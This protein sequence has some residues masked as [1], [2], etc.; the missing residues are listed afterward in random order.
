MISANLTTDL[1]KKLHDIYIHLGDHYQ[2]YNRI[3]ALNGLAGIALFQ[4]YYE[5]RYNLHSGRGFDSLE[6]CIKKINEGNF[7]ASYCNGLAGFGWLLNHLEEYKFV[8]D[9]EFV[10]IGSVIDTYIEN[11][12]D[13]CI[14]QHNYDFFHGTLGSIFYF[15]KKSDSTNKYKNH[16]SLLFSKLP[17]LYDTIND[18][19]LSKVAVPEAIEGKLKKRLH[20]GPAHGIS[21]IIAILCM[22]Y[23]K[24]YFREQSILWI[25]EF[26]QLILAYEM[27]LDSVSEFPM[28]IDLQTKEKAT[29]SLSWCSGDTGIGITL[30]NTS[31]TLGNRIWKDQSSNIL[32][33]ACQRRHI[34]QSMIKGY[35]ICHG[36]FGASRI[37]SRAYSLNP[38][39]EFEE[40]S[41]YWL[42][43][44]MD[45]LIITQDSP[46]SILNGLAGAGL[47]M[48]DF[49]HNKLSNWDECL[50]I[51]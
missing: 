31:E 29:S 22:A 25:D 27:P 18:Y 2:Q 12:L 13:Q 6:H 15:L 42:K 16:I 14:R 9:N 51:S 34:Q 10:Q 38:I 44:G 26:V 8:E 33:K 28:W 1:D 45:S 49:Q 46:M 36:Y 11:H 47:V 19:D 21:S 4:F 5:E 30:L 43:E 7:S 35:G 41:I 48:L 32:K 39:Q 50:L 40:A 24:G 37:F 20:L 17:H 3:G 23:N